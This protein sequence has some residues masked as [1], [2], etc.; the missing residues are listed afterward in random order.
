MRLIKTTP[1][2]ANPPSLNRPLFPDTKTESTNPSRRPGWPAFAARGS[3]GRGSDRAACL[4]LS[5]SSPSRT[6][7]PAT[8]LVARRH[9]SAG[10]NSGIRGDANGQNNKDLGQFQL[11]ARIRPLLA[12]GFR[13]TA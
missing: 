13:L 3:G 7:N 8:A 4:R 1:P 12:E 6:P 5:Q 9:G 2:A 11:L 10:K